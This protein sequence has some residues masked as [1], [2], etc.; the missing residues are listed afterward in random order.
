MSARDDAGPAF[1][2]GATVPDPR[3][4]GLKWEQVAGMSLRDYFAGKA[5]QGIL[6][7]DARGSEVAEDDDFA[8]V[9]ASFAYQV[10]DAMIR[11]RGAA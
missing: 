10:A 8:S 3:S 7:H 1:P 9:T 4:G 11:A 6:A 2:M 5:L